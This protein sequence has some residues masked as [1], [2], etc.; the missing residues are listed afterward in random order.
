MSDVTTDEIERKTGLL[1][2]LL[3]YGSPTEEQAIEKV[4]PE[5]SVRNR[6]NEPAHIRT[7]YGSGYMLACDVKW[8]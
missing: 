8:S 7:I 1:G 4:D 5:R 6:K 3:E 2:L